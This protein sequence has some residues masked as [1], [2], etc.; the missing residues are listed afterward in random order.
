MKLL[1]D[2]FGEIEYFACSALGRMPDPL[3]HSP[4][5]PVGVLD[6]LLWVLGFDGAA[7][8]VAP[9]NPVKP[10]KQVERARQ[11]GRGRF[12]SPPR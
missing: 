12:Q 3:D 1:E 5:E 11:R 6:P 2:N 10:V 7:D 4:F 9:A 8:E